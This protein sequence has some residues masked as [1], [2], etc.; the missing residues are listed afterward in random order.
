MARIDRK[1]LDSAT[2]PV[3][4]RIPPR[5]DDLDMQGHV[6]NAAAAVILQEARGGFNQ[7]IGMRDALEGRRVVVAAVSIE[8]AGEMGYPAPVDVAIG[9]LAIGRSSVTLWQVARQEGISKLYAE[10]VMVFTHPDGPATIPDRL[11]SAYEKVL[12]A[13]R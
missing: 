9:V 12:I 11:R 3:V 4:I 10:A 5:Y 2:D 13:Q 7:A 8:Y 1:L 6:N